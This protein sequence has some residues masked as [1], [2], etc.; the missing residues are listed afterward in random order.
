MLTFYMYNFS[1]IFLLK[2][3][4]TILFTYLKIILLH[5]FSVFSFQLY[6]NESL[7]SLSL[8]LSLNLRFSDS[9]KKKTCVSLSLSPP[10]LPPLQVADRKRRKKIKKPSRTLMRENSQLSLMGC[11]SFSPN[12][13]QDVFL[14]KLGY[15]LQLPTRQQWR[16]GHYPLI[17]AQGE[18]NFPFF[19]AR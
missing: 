5:C 19:L 15:H 2:I 18:S 1:A 6:P 9:Q 17:A 7:V 12:A 13:K 16:L 8:S 10:P 3:G 11:G 4:H 14:S